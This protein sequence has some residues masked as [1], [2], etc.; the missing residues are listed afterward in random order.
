MR[1]RFHSEPQRIFYFV[2]LSTPWWPLGKMNKLEFF[3]AVHGPGAPPKLEMQP[4]S[5]E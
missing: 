3:A 1:A 4:Y 2:T 5:D